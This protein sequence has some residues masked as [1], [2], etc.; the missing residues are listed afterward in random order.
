MNRLVF[1]TIL[2]AFP[3]FST[4]AETPHA[5][6]FE[7]ASWSPYLVGG[8]LGVLTWLTFYF[9]DK[10]VGASSFYATI[11]GKLGML[12]APKH[13]KSLAYFKENPPKFGWEAVFVL[14]TIVGGLAAA[15]TGGD[16]NNQWLPDMWAAKFGSDSLPSRAIA[17]VGGG[18]LMAFG[19]RMAGGCTSGHGISGTL[20]LNVASWIAVI[21]FFVGGIALAHLIFRT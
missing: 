17:G 15:L 8:L 12:I 3:L 19:A 6:Q 20:Q 1:L 5:K 4:A 13:T 14:A 2:F 21:S 18:I 16:F 9:S 11:A 7:P 10:P